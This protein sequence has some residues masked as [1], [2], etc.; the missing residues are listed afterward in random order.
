MN[1]FSPNAPFARGVNK[2]VTM[3]YAGSLWFLFSLPVITMGAATAALYEVFFKVLKNQESYIARS[4]FKAFRSNLK[5]GVLLGVPLLAAQAIFAWNLFYYGVLGGDGFRVQKI[6]F[7]VVSLVTL[8]LFPWVFGVMAKFENSTSGHLRLA[9]A[10]L[11]RCPGWS[12]AILVIQA[13]TVFLTWFFVYFPAVFIAGIGGYLEAA[14]FDHV[15]QR[16]IDSGVIEE[17]RE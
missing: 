4:F 2:L 15:F 13:L 9:A 6:V 12:L 7:T 1:L 8:T 5:Q 11:V 16:L 10:I 17:A 14:V 3:L